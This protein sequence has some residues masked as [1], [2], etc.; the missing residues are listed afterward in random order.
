MKT[1]IMLF[2]AVVALSSAPATFGQYYQ[3]PTGPTAPVYSA[4]QWANSTVGQNNQQTMNQNVSYANN[5]LANGN[6]ST[7]CDNVGGNCNCG[8]SH[9]GGCGAYDPCCPTRYISIFGGVSDFQDIFYSLDLDDGAGGTL[10]LDAILATETGWA[11]G[12]A[13]GRSIG[14]RMRGEVTFTYRTASVEDGSINIGGQP[15]GSLDLDGSLNMYAF[16]PNLLYDFCPKS[17]FNP[18]VGVGS[19]IVFQDLE[20]VEPTIPVSVELDDS[21]WAYQGIVGISSCLNSRTEMFVE[22]RFFE[23]DEFKLDVGT[24]IGSAS[25]TTDT[26]A[27]NVLFGLRIQRR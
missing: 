9:C 23:T 1:R 10:D 24:P 19:G 11:A 16:M 15:I 26:T 8:S 6:G 5:Y 25:F 17:K 12:A 18:Y 7:G 2:L 13:V 22:Y 27:H 14:R 4:Q 21:S 20:V 3:Q